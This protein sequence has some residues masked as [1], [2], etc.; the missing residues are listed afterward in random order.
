M[1]KWAMLIAAAAAALGGPLAV[2]A[3]QGYRPKLV[4]A[5]TLADAN[6]LVALE[7][8]G[9]VFFVDGFEAPESLKKYFEIRGLKQ[10]RA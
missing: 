1:G 4:T 9:K 7:K 3:Q 5:Q 8:P 2:R 10:G 6:A